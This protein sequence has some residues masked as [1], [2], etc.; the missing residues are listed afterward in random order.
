MSVCSLHSRLNLDMMPTGTSERSAGSNMGEKQQSAHSKKKKK[1][2]LNENSKKKEKKEIIIT[3][4]F[5]ENESP[6]WPAK[7]LLLQV[8]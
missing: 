4:V 5:M 6:L 1:S 8:P 7:L 2:V 3:V